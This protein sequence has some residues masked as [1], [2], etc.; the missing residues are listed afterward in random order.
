[1][2]AGKPKKSVPRKKQKLIKASVSYGPGGD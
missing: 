2:Q 1:M